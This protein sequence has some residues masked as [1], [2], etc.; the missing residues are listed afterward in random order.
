MSKIGKQPINI[1][2]DVTVNLENYKVAISGPKG[3]LSITLRPEIRIKTQG[4]KL[5]VERVN[6]ERLS[7]SLH[8]LTRTL[9]ANM[10]SG[11]TQGWSKE[12]EMVGVGYR[13]Q[14]LNGNLIL[15]VGYSHPVEIKSLEGIS[16]EVKGNNRIVV[17][18]IDKEKVG[19]VAAQIRKVRPPEPYKGKGIRYVG[20]Q[21]RRKPGKAAKVVGGMQ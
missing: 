5:L 21:V 18:G 7:K 20:E 17:A 15:N 14:V 9:L 2:N 19:Q 4:D 10:I 1:P 12:L 11:V 3:S 8:G 6:D 16:F 13:A